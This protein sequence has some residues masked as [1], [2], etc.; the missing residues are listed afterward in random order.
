[1]TVTV[2]GCVARVQ[3]CINPIPVVSG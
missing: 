3:K 1:M 2:P